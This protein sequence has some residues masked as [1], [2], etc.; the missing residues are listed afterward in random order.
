MLPVNFFMS[1]LRMAAISSAMLLITGCSS[2]LYYPT[3]AIY[4][5]LKKLNPPPEERTLDLG[6]GMTS[7]GWYF[8]A[9]PGPSK[10]VI[11]FFHGN[12]QN[13]SA[14]FLSLYW[15][16]REGYDLAI[17][18]YPG[19][20]K[21]AGKPTPE[22]TV[23][24]AIAAIRATFRERGGKPFIVYG[25]SLG[26]AVALRALWELRQEVKPDFL[27]ID[28]SFLSYQR[29][30]R[31]I[32][33]RSAWTWM[34]QPAAWLVLSDRWAPGEQVENLSIPTIV[35]HSK[36]DEIIPFKVGENTFAH[37][38]RPK[39]FWTK[40]TGAHNQTFEDVEGAKLKTR[41]LE[42]LRRL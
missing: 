6:G 18:D 28:S 23:K 14:H 41:L 16:T 5:D 11:L 27:V 29:V 39:E 17:Y 24:M 22:S 40:E 4:V 34:L 42:A 20:G 25:Q 12:G 35:I 15:L 3:R 30:A 7:Y 26:G 2:L 38:P 19:Y 32:V 37:A 36:K 9:Q 21:T 13:R 33:A 10:G 1:Y 31:K 8:K